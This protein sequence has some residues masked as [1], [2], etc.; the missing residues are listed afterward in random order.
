M[1]RIVPLKANPAIEKI[2]RSNEYDAARAQPPAA[3]AAE[4]AEAA[5]AIQNYNTTDKLVTEKIVPD[6]SKINEMTC[7]VHHSKQTSGKVH[8]AA[9]QRNTGIELKI[10]EQVEP[11]SSKIDRN[12]PEENDEMG[13][14]KE[15]IVDGDGK[16]AFY[17]MESILDVRKKN[18]I[19][20][21]LVHWKGCSRKDASWE[22]KSNLCDSA[23][24]LLFICLSCTYFTLPKHFVLELH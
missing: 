19:W 6:Q 4:A 15:I 22:P 21:Y 7:E 24:K 10:T 5:A 23:C 20:E 17:E 12:I 11:D 3:A 18:G 16:G 9:V 13:S 2:K 14:S 1:N 8:S